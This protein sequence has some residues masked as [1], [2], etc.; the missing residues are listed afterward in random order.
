MSSATAP[1][2][3]KILTSVETLSRLRFRDDLFRAFAARA[4][5]L[6]QG[7]MA[8]L[9]RA[10]SGFY[11]MGLVP[12]GWCVPG[13][14]DP[15]WEEYAEPE[16]ILPADP[17]LAEII[18]ES[19]DTHLSG[20]RVQGSGD[21]WRLACTIETHTREHLVLELQTPYP[22]ERE[23][24]EGIR[25]FLQCFE[26]QLRQ[27]EYA[28]LDTLTGLL[29][30]KTFDEQFDQFIAEAER[31]ER[32]VNERR[33]DDF[34]GNR[35][36]WLGVVDIDHF[37]SVNDRFGHQI[38]DQVLQEV[39]SAMLGLFRGSDKLFRFGGEEFVIM[40]RGVSEDD[41][42]NIFD[43]F[44][45]AIS[46]LDIAPVGMVTTSVGYARIDP[47][48]KPGELLGRADQALYYAKAHGRDQVRGF[49]DLIMSGAIAM[50]PTAQPAVDAGGGELFFD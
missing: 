24:L 32:R 50:P 4:L 7:R 10:T 33:G 29:N 34:R 21:G 39:A 38:G 27:W 40:L 14:D 41:V 30:R 1:T 43:R 49:D 28:N 42:F 46:T 15:H 11:G 5:D 44:R 18:A 23:V 3:L 48:Y 20:L 45:A 37:K 19:A 2:L 9:Y 17:F 12:L 6:V 16:T 35:P 8:I 13:D 31:A 26:N 36:C 22:P 25:I 47:S